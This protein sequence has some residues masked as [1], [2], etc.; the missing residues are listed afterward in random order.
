MSWLT[1]EHLPLMRQEGP[2][3]IIMNTLHDQHCVDSGSK[4]G[5]LYKMQ[6]SCLGY[7]DKSFAQEGI[8][9][10]CHPSLCL[11]KVPT[12]CWFTWTIADPGQVCAHL[13][14]SK[15]SRAKSSLHPTHSLF[16]ATLHL[17]SLD[18]SFC[19]LPHFVSFSL[20]LR[21]YFHQITSLSQSYPWI[22]I[23]LANVYWV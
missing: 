8:V 3:M 19:L 5:H 10:M 21:L 23:Y 2:V 6:Y 17:F 4:L 22:S 14:W 12:L 1:A 11:P 16:S 20:P 13:H 9:W 18:L 7:A 15:C